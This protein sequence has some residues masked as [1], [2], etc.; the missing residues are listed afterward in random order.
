[1]S[2]QLLQFIKKWLRSWTGGQ[3]AVE[4]LLQ[5]YSIDAFYSDPVR[6]QGLKGKAELK[7]YFEKLLS[8]NPEWVWTAEA[9]FP[10]AK[11]FT[12]K[13]KAIIPQAEKVTTLYGM[14][15]VELSQ[16]L[17]TRNEVYFDPSALR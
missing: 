13:W 12:L 6:P 15:L 4:G 5:F 2:E 9:I 10:N 11:G 7:K 3:A 17:I 14:D 16:N 1:M 8:K